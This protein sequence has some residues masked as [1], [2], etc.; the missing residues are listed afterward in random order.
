L[1]G[2]TPPLLQIKAEP[3]SAAAWRTR[4]L[5]PKGRYQFSAMVKTEGVSIKRNAKNPGARLRIPGHSPERSTS[6][7]GTQPWTK[8]MLAFEVT[9]PEQTVEML[10]ELSADSGEAFFREDALL[11]ERIQ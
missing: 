2:G 7:M 9:E 3:G 6:L 11:I 5:L 8:L 10:C 1:A 4:L